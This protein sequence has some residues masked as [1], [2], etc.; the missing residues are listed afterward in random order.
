M[1]MSPE[2]STSPPLSN[3]DLLL[4]ILEAVA[5]PK[6][7]RGIEIVC[8]VILA[9]ATTCSAWCAYQSKLWGGVQAA[10][11]NAAI[12]AGREQAVNTLAAFQ[13]RAFDA[14]M[15][16]TYMEAKIGGNREWENFLA[17]RFRPD[18]KPAVEAWLALD[19]QHNLSA[20]SSPFQ[21]AEYAQKETAAIAH[22]QNLSDEA[23]RN[24]REARNFSDDYVLLTV[25]FATVLFLGGI[26]RAFDAGAL[27]T[28]L[29]VLAVV[30][31]VATVAGLCT[32]PVCHL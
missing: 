29:A 31:F 10:S 8:A 32:M 7:R 25:L 1:L 15:F 20:P 30:L 4:R 17:P 2:P 19:P 13:W 24:S 28:S 11:G 23:L 12:R 26:A 14:S 3:E 27:R 6:R 9:L 18:M 22:Y 16:I 5:P 21:M